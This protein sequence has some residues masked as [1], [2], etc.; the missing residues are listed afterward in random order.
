MSAQSPGAVPRVAFL[1]DTFGEVNGAALTSRRLA[2]WAQERRR[3]FLC[4]FAGGRSRVDVDDR[5]GEVELP[6]SRLGIPLEA[7]LSYDVLGWRHGRRL[8]R[9]LAEFRPDVVHVTGPNDMG[10]LGAYLAWRLG[11]PLVA[12]WHTNV[13]EF[14]ARRAARWLDVAPAAVSTRLSAI[15]ERSVLRATAR[16]YR[17]A[18]VVLA[19]ND[20]LVRQLQALTGRPVRLM[21]RGVDAERFSPAYRQRAADDGFRIGYVGRL[22]PEKDVRA[23]VGL[24]AALRE[25]NPLRPYELVVVGDGH[26]RAWLERHLPHARFTG[27]LGGDALARAYA[28]MDA[29]YFPSRTDAFGNVVLEALAS[30]TPAI[31]TSAGGP[32]SIVADGVTGFVAD[33]E[34]DACRAVL[35][36]MHDPHAFARMRSAARERALESSWDRVFDTV[37]SA[38]RQALDTGPHPLP[39]RAAP[40]PGPP[41]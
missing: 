10:Q 1:P 36:L 20:A 12:S 21:R 26:E 18:R 15:I 24:D 7:D 34:A 31:V 2:R 25:A 33:T 8:H 11:V 14:A 17:L 19:P 38:Y 16:F 13:H 3:P 27:V 22:S 41:R 6:R 40:A 29:L 32:A 23:L 30:G 28:D 5:G 4:A 37:Y 39:A 35:R 9:L